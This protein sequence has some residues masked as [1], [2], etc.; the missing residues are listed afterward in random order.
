MQGK[1]TGIQK[2][3]LFLKTSGQR[4]GC[5]CPS[6]REKSAGQRVYEDTIIRVEKGEFDLYDAA[7]LCLIRKRIFLKKETDEFSQIILDE[8]QD[9]GESVFVLKQVL[10]KCYFTIM[11][12]VF[13]NIR[14]ETGLNN[15]SGKC[16]R[17]LF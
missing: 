10:A 6:G 12:D 14:Y 11:G 9:F 4:P 13:Q 8:A 1:I 2:L 3:V 17:K 7:A 5:I 16:E 15:S